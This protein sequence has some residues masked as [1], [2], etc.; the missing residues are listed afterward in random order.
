MEEGEE[1]EEG[2][3]EAQ[4]AAGHLS[5]VHPGSGQANAQLGGQGPQ[6]QGLASDVRAGRGRLGR[7]GRWET[8]TPS[9]EKG[10]LEGP[11]HPQGGSVIAESRWQ[12]RGP[13]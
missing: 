12:P 3:G 9:T 10:V 5:T 13:A 1:G 6:A 7:K 8:L 2:R 4:E 11:F